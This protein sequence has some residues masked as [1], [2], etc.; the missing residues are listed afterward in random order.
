MSYYISHRT[1]CESNNDTVLGSIPKKVDQS[2][3]EYQQDDLRLEHA[4]DEAR[5]TKSFCCYITSFVNNIDL[6]CNKN[7]RLALNWER[8]VLFLS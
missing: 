3:T 6:V 2:K 8:V 4:T 1:Y 7:P 5:N